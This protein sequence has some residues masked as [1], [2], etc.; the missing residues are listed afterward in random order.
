MIFCL[1]FDYY[2]FLSF[3]LFTSH[4]TF[5]NCSL[6]GLVANDEDSYRYLV[7]SIRRF[8]NQESLLAMVTQAGFQS[9]SYRNFTFG[10]VAVHSGFKL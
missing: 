4:F 10:V 6:E 7:E 8:P 5:P 9:V 3:A 1:S 2:L